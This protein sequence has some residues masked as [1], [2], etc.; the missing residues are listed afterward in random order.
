MRNS[1]QLAALKLHFCFQLRGLVMDKQDLMEE[2]FYENL[3]DVPGDYESED[4][5]GLLAK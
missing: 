2:Q 4:C 3:S 1:G 5:E